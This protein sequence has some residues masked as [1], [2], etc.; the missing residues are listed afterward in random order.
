VSFGRQLWCVFRR[1]AARDT[2]RK[3]RQGSPNTSPT[4]TMTRLVAIVVM[5]SFA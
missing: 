1:G 5:G 3:S 4:Q 2:D